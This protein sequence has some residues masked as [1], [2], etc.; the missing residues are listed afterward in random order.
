MCTVTDTAAEMTIGPT[1]SSTPHSSRH[2]TQARLAPTSMHS[3]DT[4]LRFRT[5]SSSLPGVATS[6]SQPPRSA[7]TCSTMVA[8]PCTRLH[9]TWV[10]EASLRASSQICCAS[11]RV[12]ARMTARG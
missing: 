11:S 12:G 9:L 6:R 2:A 3:S 5:W 8:P 4:L 1:C 10:P 7:S